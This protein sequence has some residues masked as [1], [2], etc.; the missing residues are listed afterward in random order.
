MNTGFVFL[1]FQGSL[2]TLENRL[3]LFSNPFSQVMTMAESSYSL[4]SF[5]IS[6]NKVLARHR[7]E[8]PTVGSISCAN[9]DDRLGIKSVQNSLECSNVLGAGLVKVSQQQPKRLCCIVHIVLC[10]CKQTRLSALCFHAQSMGDE[11][12]ESLCHRWTLRTSSK[13]RPCYVVSEGTSFQ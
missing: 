8:K 1:V 13:S 3:R 6:N 10:A 12:E 4:D 5:F 7:C 9:R 2:L 11:Q